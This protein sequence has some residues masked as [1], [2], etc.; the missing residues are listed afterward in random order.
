MGTPGVPNPHPSKRVTLGHSSLAM[1]SFSEDVQDSK[2]SG[3]L[4]LLIVK[5]TW[6]VYMQRLENK[7][8]QTPPTPRTLHIPI[9]L[10]LKKILFIYF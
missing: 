3:L 1:D 9:L 7:L 8:T 4:N 5:G 6:R 2:D 10:F